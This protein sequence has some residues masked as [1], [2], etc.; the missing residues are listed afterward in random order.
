MDTAMAL[1][2]LLVQVHAPCIHV[3]LTSPAGAVVLLL[4][5]ATHNFTDGLAIGV[6]RLP[7]KAICANP[8]SFTGAAF[9][10]SPS[11]GIATTFAVFF[12]EARD[13]TICTHVL[14]NAIVSFRCIG[15]S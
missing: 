5:D 3:P 9:L 11:R 13:Y 10:L 6:S 14:S 15:A 1:A 7:C 4:A 12:H 8:D 2:R